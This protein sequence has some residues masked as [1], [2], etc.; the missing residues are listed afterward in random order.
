MFLSISM[1]TCQTC[2]IFQEYIR[3]LRDELI[4]RKKPDLFSL[5]G[6]KNL[7]TVTDHALF[8]IWLR[9]L[10]H[11]ILFSGDSSHDNRRWVRI[12]TFTS[13]LT[14]KCETDRDM[15]P[16]IISIMSRKWRDAA[17]DDFPSLSFP[18]YVFTI[19]LHRLNLE[20]APSKNATSLQWYRTLSAVWAPGLSSFW[21]SLTLSFK[22]S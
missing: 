3:G 11:L 7:P 16:Y 17:R 10:I 4:E 14:W 6:C 2:L 9:D 22:I 1:I 13:V 21:S 8:S 19:L 5:T 18:L 15:A 20:I 12:P